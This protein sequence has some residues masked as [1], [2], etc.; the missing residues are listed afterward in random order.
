MNLNDLENRISEIASKFVLGEIEKQNND[1]IGFVTDSLMIG[2]FRLMSH[3]VIETFFEA[4]ARKARDRLIVSIKSPDFTKE[5]SMFFA[6]AVYLKMTINYEKNF[7]QNEFDAFKKK[8]SDEIEKAI[9]A[10]NGIKRDFF[11]LLGLLHGER[12]DQLDELLMTELDDFA[13]HRG[14]VAHNDIN[15]VRTIRAPSDEKAS[16]ESII[17]LIKKQS[18]LC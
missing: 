6:L 9:A 3:S 12:I 11:K 4:S 2:A 7:A 18:W 1:P 8:V 5:T 17:Q 15:R 10:N 16:V 14:D 13:R